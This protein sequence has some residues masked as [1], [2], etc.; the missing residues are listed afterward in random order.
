MNNYDFITKT[1]CIAI[2][3]LRA[4]GLW[5][6]Y[7]EERL[8]S[9]GRYSRPWCHKEFSKVNKCIKILENTLGG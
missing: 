2:L 8:D 9:N 3:R 6:K 1:S 5:M 7:K 4:R